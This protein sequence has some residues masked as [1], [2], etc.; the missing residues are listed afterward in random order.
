MIGLRVLEVFTFFFNI[1]NARNK[2]NFHAARDKGE[3]NCS[4]RYIRKDEHEKKSQIGL[5]EE[6]NGEPKPKTD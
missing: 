6:K 2:F 4:N 3:N 5:R 1:R